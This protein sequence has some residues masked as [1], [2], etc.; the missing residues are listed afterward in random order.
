MDLEVEELRRWTE[1]GYVENDTTYSERE[2][3]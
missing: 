3:A 2:P 1:K